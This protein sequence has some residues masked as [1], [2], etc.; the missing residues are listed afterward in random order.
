MAPPGTYAGL[1][2]DSPASDSRGASSCSR[3]G[4][5]VGRACGAST[6]GGG[7]GCG[8]LMGVRSLAEPSVWPVVQ[9][10]PV[11]RRCRN[12]TC[13]GASGSCPSHYVNRQPHRSATAVF[14]RRIG[15]ST[16]V[17]CGGGHSRAGR[18]SGV[19]FLG[20]FGWS[21]WKAVAC[22][23]GKS[24]EVT[25]PFVNVDAVMWAVVTG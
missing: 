14:R 21:R 1:F 17:R 23:A 10:S 25:R 18:S 9:S 4:G 19:R 22:F 7:S 8:C 24:R 11:M 2:E 12:P 5:V 3:R 13:S 6:P 15:R 16:P 20:P